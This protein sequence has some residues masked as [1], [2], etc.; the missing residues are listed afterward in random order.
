M[1][2]LKRRPLQGTPH[3]WSDDVPAIMQQIYAA[4][5]VVDPTGISR[6]LAQMLSPKLM[7]G[8][9]Q[10]V[11]L[12]AEAIR[13]HQHITVAG[14]YDCDGAT[15]TA[16]AVRGLKMLGATNVGFILPNRAIH[17]YGLSPLLVDDMDPR[18]QVIVTVDSGVSSVEG[19]ARAKA[20]GR[21]VIVTDHHLPGEILPAADAIVNPNLNGDPFPSKAL[22]GVGVVFYVLLALRS[23]LRDRGAWT[24]PEPDLATLLDLVALGTVADLVP[25]DKNNRI[26]VDAGLR[27][28]RDGQGHVGIQALIQSAKK[29]PA[30]IVA[31]D[32]AFSVAPRLNA[33]GRLEDMRLGVLTLITDDQAEAEAHVAEL[34]RINTERRAI[35]ATMVSEA[36]NLVLTTDV[37]NTTGVVVFDPSWHS[38]VVGLVA[39]K[40][41]ES[42]HRPVVAFAPP[43]AGSPNITG[44]ARS[45]SGFHLRDALALIDAKNPKLIIKFGG[46][47]MA[48]GL[49]IEAKNLERF[50]KAFDQ[51]AAEGLNEEQLSAVLFTDG[52]LPA[53]YIN[54]DFAYY[55]RLCGP[56]G[57]GFPEPV[58]ENTFD[59]SDYKVLGTTH[60]KLDLTDPRDGS[61]IQ[62]IF[63]GGYKGEAPPEMVRVAYDLSINT[64]KGNDSLQ[65]LIRDLKPV[66]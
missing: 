58:F 63:F 43:S 7:G 65:L 35:Q 53:G 37:G 6:R 31:S 20:L 11:E 12:L 44:S 62:A 59:V 49:T 30:Y 19:V 64:W 16:V 18:T 55:V 40:L 33:A 61:A 14:D 41:K 27:R 25:L 4:R 8:M 2:M 17:G 15:G 5:G 60:L 23:L 51:V 47:A 38:G 21:M 36:E 28:I 39:S 29:D 57:Q 50:R 66:T 13:T 45:I 22:A 26:L 10:A 1:V 48:A 3:G 34:E 56:W 54:L 46:H 24:G 9:A 32:I 52:E 42:L